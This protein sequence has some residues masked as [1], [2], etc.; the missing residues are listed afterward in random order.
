MAPQ[1]YGQIPHS[2]GGCGRPDQLQGGYNSPPP[3]ASEYQSQA[4]DGKGGL[5]FEI[6]RDPTWP[7]KAV[8]RCS[9]V[10]EE[11]QVAPVDAAAQIMSKVRTVVPH[12]PLAN[13]RTKLT[14]AK[15][16][17]SLKSDETRHGPTRPWS[18][19]PQCWSSTR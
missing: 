15:G 11:C 3:T 9:T 16:V 18:D 19:A 7:Q 2:A 5:V 10:L 4:D 6:G 13:T 14:T 8:V 17:S 1:G 12:H